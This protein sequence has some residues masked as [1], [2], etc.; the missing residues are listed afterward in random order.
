MGAGPDRAPA[1]RGAGLDL[2]QG[3]GPIADIEIE[4][5]TLCRG[6]IDIHDCH[7]SAPSLGACRSL[8]ELLKGCRRLGD[9][10]LRGYRAKNFK[11]RSLVFHI[12]VRL[13]GLN[14][15]LFNGWG[16]AFSPFVFIPCHD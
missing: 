4:E 13:V 11:P 7:F 8:A 2:V 3:I 6:V 1:L 16:R 10:V 14:E 15:G 5:R 9:V 12:K